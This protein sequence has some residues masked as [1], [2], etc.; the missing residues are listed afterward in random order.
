MNILVPRAPAILKRRL[1]HVGICKKCNTLIDYVRARGGNG[2]DYIIAT[3][4]ETT[5]NLDSTFYC[6]TGSGSKGHQ[7][8]VFFGKIIKLDETVYTRSI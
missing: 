4:L 1:H 5:T 8:K 7:P 6:N 3:H 2:L